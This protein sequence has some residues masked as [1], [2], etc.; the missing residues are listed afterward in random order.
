MSDYSIENRQE[1]VNV[2][3]SRVIEN[4]PLRELIR[5]YSEAVGAAIANLSDADVVRSISAA[6]YTDILEAFE[7]TVPAAEETAEAP[8][9][10]AVPA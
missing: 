7:L 2:L 3:T 6:G 8:E 10:E 5:V 4:A 1:V 9:G